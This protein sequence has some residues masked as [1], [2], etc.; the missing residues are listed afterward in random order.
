MW[1]CTLRLFTHTST[2]PHNL[3]NSASQPGEQADSRKSV[4]GTQFTA[5]CRAL[6]PE[7]AQNHCCAANP[8]DNMS[9][10]LL[11]T[12]LRRDTT[13]NRCGGLSHP[14]NNRTATLHTLCVRPRISQC[15]APTL[16]P[17]LEQV[18]IDA[19]ASRL[20]EAPRVSVRPEDPG[21]GAERFPTMMAFRPPVCFF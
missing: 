18:L 13:D 21:H 20:P 3:E 1:L 4:E 7:T 10:R 11:T 2:G 15:H 5:I 17:L 16:T 9:N 19:R 8:L 14:K 12:Q 6:P